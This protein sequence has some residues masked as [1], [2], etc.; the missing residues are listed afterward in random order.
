MHYTSAFLS[1]S[2]TYINFLIYTYN[3]IQLLKM[4]M[5]RQLSQEVSMQG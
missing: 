4:W 1:D 3:I 5:T 2:G